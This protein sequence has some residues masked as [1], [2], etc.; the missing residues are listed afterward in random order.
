MLHLLDR[1]DKLKS[2][3]SSTSTETSDANGFVG[4]HYRRLAWSA[5]YFAV[6]VG[7][8]KVVELLPSKGMCVEETNCNGQT[9]FYPPC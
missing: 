9:P 2:M 8:P 6:D 7:R 5:L 3:A 4:F 1:A